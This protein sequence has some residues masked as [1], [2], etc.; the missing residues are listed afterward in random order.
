MASGSFESDQDTYEGSAVRWFSH[1]GWA[2][3]DPCPAYTALSGGVTRTQAAGSKNERP[4]PS[5]CQNC[6]PQLEITGVGAGASPSLS[7]NERVPHE[8]TQLA[9]IS[10][11]EHVRILRRKG[12]FT[13]EGGQEPIAQVGEQIAAELGENGF[14]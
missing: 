1:L 3:L 14:L 12:R 8:V 9:H 13:A 5:Q 7:A 10:L 2:P 6:L 11:G 4:S